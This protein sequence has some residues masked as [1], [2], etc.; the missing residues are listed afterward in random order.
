MTISAIGAPR[1]RPFSGMAIGAPG[2]G[3]PGVE[4]GLR[5]AM[6]AAADFI[7]RSFAHLRPSFFKSRPPLSR[8]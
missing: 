4:R 2:T 7:D 1:T 8:S 3:R 5:G 6:L